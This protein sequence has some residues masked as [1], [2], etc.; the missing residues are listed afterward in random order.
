MESMLISQALRELKEGLKAL[1]G[2]RLEGLYLYGSYAR[3]A[4]SVDS[5]VD[6]L[7]VLRG[8]VNAG[9]EISQLNPVVSTI[10][11]KYDLLI[12]ICPV[13]VESLQTR[14]SPF[15]INVRTEAIAI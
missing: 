11:L 4:E 8:A 2:R 5:D 14:Q 9:E 13:S 1:Y 7:A 12:S 6:V 15:L 10:C 3:N